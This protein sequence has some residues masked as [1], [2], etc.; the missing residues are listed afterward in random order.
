MIKECANCE[1]NADIPPGASVLAGLPGLVRVQQIGAPAENN[2]SGAFIIG[3]TAFTDLSSFEGL[4]C[5]PGL[6]ELTNNSRLASLK[7][8]DGVAHQPGVFFVARGNP[9]S[10][11]ASLRAIAR[12]AGCP[13]SL[14]SPQTSSLLIAS[15]LCLHEVG[16]Q[17][18]C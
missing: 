12:L 4:R 8:L 18:F 9:L 15:T 7:G 6:V 10:T 3:N 14:R 5:P 13:A 17:T 11:P 1:V 2:V 16:H